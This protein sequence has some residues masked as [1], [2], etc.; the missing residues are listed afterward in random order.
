MLGA[1][2]TAFY[3]KLN[4]TEPAVASALVHHVAAKAHTLI[5]EM[6]GLRSAWLPGWRVRIL[7]GNH[8]AAT[9]RRLEVLWG[10]SA[11]PLPGFALVAFDPSSML[12]THVIPCE[13]GHAQERSLTPQILAL[14]DE[15]D[16][17]IADRNFCT[18]AILSGIIHRPA[19]LVI[20]QHL[21]LPGRVVGERTSCGRTATGAVFEQAY[22]FEYEG[23]IVTLRRI[24]VELDTPTRD[25]ETSLHLLTNLPASVDAT[26]IAELYLKRWTLETAFGHLATWLDAE[27]APLG[28]PRAALLGFCVGLVAYNT[29]STLLGALRSIHGEK[30]VAEQVSGYYLVE[31]GRGAVGTIDELVEPPAWQSWRSLTL[32]AAACLLREIA[33]RIDLAKIRKSPRGPKNPVPKRTRF[34]D[35]PHVSTQKLL[36]QAAEEAWE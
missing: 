32:A 10:V 20:R 34:K 30:L 15:G 5:T 33:A 29:I 14:V 6:G 12:M 1:S 11:G 4:G 26:T 19:A 13:D 28:Y 8:L 3:N 18:Q 7:D 35:K 17:W 21:N 25:G 22:E 36:N 16:C 23:Q 31:F 2:F 24:T 27:I 9:E